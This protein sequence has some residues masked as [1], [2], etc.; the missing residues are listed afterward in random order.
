MV[1]I[2]G[3]NKSVEFVAYSYLVGV[4]AEA[5]TRREF[6]NAGS[7]GLAAGVQF[8]PI[9]TTHSPTRQIFNKVLSHISYKNQI[10][11]FTGER[12]QQVK[13][14]LLHCLPTTVVIKKTSG[15]HLKKC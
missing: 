3:R 6:N 7:S 13:T 2:E 11:T 9:T 10:N 1:N 8:S 5:H 4:E 14:F 15:Y 12:I